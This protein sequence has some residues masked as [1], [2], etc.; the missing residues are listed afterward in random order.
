MWM[1]MFL[2]DTRC[3]TLIHAVHVNKDEMCENVRENTRCEGVLFTPVGY[4]GSL[5]T[6]NETNCDK[7][8]IRAKKN[9]SSLPNPFGCVPPRWTWSWRPIL[10]YTCK[11]CTLGVDI[12]TA[13]LPRIPSQ[14]I[15]SLY[16]GLAVSSTMGSAF[17]YH[18]VPDRDCI[19][20]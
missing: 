10:P 19:Q 20:S 5:S 15:F 9:V 6:V 11:M 14:L 7:K 16:L 3:N 18:A 8:V 1:N 12:V 4:S 17:L 13:S 2:R